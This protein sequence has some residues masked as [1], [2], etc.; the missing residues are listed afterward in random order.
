MGYGSKL[1]LQIERDEMLAL[2]DDCYRGIPGIHRQVA[3]Y[4]FRLI[5]WPNCEVCSAPSKPPI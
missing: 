1:S 2:K 5:V 4:A 3:A